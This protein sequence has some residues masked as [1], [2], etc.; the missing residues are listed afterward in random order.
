MTNPPLMSGH[1]PPMIRK[2]L[3]GGEGH[4]LR[5]AAWVAVASARDPYTPL[6]GLLGDEG[7]HPCLQC[8]VGA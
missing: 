6:V 5:R 1:D 3:S 4:H 7:C 8:G 2:S